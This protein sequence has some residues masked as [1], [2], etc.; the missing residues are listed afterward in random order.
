MKIRENLKMRLPRPLASTDWLA[1]NLEEPNLRIYD[2]TLYVEYKGDTGSFG[3]YNLDPET[4]RNEWANEHI[5]G[6]C[7]IDISRQLFDP[8]QSIPFMMPS[9][10]LFARA[11]TALGIADNTAVVLFSKGCQMWATRVW[12]ML[13][14]IGFDNVAVLDG[15]WE[16]WKRENRP[17]NNM[18][19]KYPVGSLSVTPRPEMW[20]NKHR[21]LQVLEAGGPTMVNA[22]PHEVY[23]G[24]LNRYGRPGHLPG[25]HSVPYESVINP[26]TGE[27]LKPD[28]LR[29]L[30][31]KSGALN[32][33][34]V[35]A[36]CGGGISATMDCMAMSLCGQDNVAVYD[37][38][39]NEWVLDE[40]LPLKLGLEP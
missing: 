26:N 5:P 7:F 39:M 37:G 3:G 17:T 11:V 23:T 8:N 32:A 18:I 16:K 10:E 38:S 12:W 27:F 9:P 15:G 30:F 24:E 2:V 25:S 34:K 13:R 20:V 6:S 31:A 40:T 19:P 4:A 35:I 36:Y 1:D 22:L 21:M 29:P 33:D 14:S 28:Q